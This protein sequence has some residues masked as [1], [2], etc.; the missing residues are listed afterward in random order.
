MI[1]LL[2]SEHPTASAITV[3]EGSNDIKLQESE[4][5]KKDFKSLNHTVLKSGKH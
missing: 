5:L 4:Q 1:P 2:I 3:H